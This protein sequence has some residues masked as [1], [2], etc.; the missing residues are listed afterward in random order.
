[1]RGGGRRL[2]GG[3]RRFC[4]TKMFLVTSRVEFSVARAARWK[5][6]REP[7]LVKYERYFKTFQTC[8]L[9]FNFCES[10]PARCLRFDS[11][12]ETE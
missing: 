4:R 5:P 11:A 8:N 6:D 7:L 12:S 3:C 10:F 2:P 9:T 1:M